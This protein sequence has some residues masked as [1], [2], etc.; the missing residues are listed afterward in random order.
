MRWVFE[1]ICSPTRAS[2]ST[3]IW[4]CTRPRSLR[5][6][7]GAATERLDLFADAE[8]SAARDRRVRRAR[9]VARLPR[10]LPRKRAR[11]YETLEQP[12]IR[13]ALP[14]MLSLTRGVGN[15]GD[16]LAIRP[17][18][19][20]WA[21]LGSHLRDPRLRQLFGR[22]ATYCGSS[23]FLAP[24]TLMLVAHVEQQGVWYVEGGMHRVA[25]ALAGLAE[26]RG[27][28]IRYEAEAAEILVS[29]RP[30]PRRAPRLRRDDRRRRRGAERRPGRPRRRPVRPRR[31]FR[32]ART[33]ARAAL[34]L[35]AHLD[36]AGRN[37]R[38]PPGP[39]QRLLLARLPGR[40]RRRSA[41]GQ[42]PSR[43]D[44][45]CLRAGSRRRRR[46]A[47]RVRSAS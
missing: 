40:V 3:I 34:A 43:A 5:A 1:Q 31:R 26:A 22:Y 27:A 6:M 46:A 25:H 11:T 19:T 12:F 16:L 30:R 37:R 2:G 18:Q 24:A 14:S 10:L 13:A 28:T 29:S 4:R 20:L 15:L 47:R 36:R 21:E 38:L 23:P 45:L 32:R 35:R 39:A 17:F 9:R 41:A 42:L 44:R 8:R 7:P 33:A